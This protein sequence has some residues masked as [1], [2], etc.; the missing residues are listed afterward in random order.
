M[1]VWVKFVTDNI[2][3]VALLLI[4][5]FGLLT[6]LSVLV[7]QQHK[8]LESS[9]L[10]RFVDKIEDLVDR[11]NSHIEKLDHLS[12]RVS[13]VEKRLGEHFIR[14]NEREKL[15]SDIGERQKSAINKYDKALLTYSKE[16]K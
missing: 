12:G 1:E 8:E 10:A 6:R 15:L 13:K 7:W 9:E 11:Q 3:L 14:C 16:I 2:I 4:A 5:G